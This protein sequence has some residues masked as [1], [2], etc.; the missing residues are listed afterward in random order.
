MKLFLAIFLGWCA[1][2][3]V[4]ATAQNVYTARNGTVTFFSKTPLE[5]IEARNDKAQAA[6]QIATGE[7]AVKILIK[8]FVFENGLMQEHFNEN[9]LE[10]DKYPFATFK[11]KIN[12]A[13]DFTK[14]GSHP[15]SATGKMNIHGVE[16]DQTIAGKLDIV[17]GKLQLQADFAVALADYKIEI[18]TLVFQKIAEKID[19]SARFTFEPSVKQ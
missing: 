5:N 10:S 3:G 13:I 8:G 19:V 9:Y 14:D 11:G 18:P 15:V 7:I 1:L 12:Q 16:R 17:E 4:T 2:A 6:I